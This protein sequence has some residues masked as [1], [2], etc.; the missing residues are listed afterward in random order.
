MQDKWLRAKVERETSGP[1]QEGGE[2]EVEAEA[3]CKDARGGKQ[4]RRQRSG[5]GAGCECGG[6][7]SRA[8]TYWTA[9]GLMLQQVGGPALGQ[10]RGGGLLLLG[11]A[12]V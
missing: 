2:E 7:R 1:Q 10:D 12:D 3:C 6:G 8:V 9:V 4:R 11:V 5:G